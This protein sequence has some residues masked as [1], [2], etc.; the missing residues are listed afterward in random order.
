M[1]EGGYHIEMVLPFKWA[2]DLWG[3]RMGETEGCDLMDGILALKITPGQ[4]RL[5]VFVGNINFIYVRKKTAFEDLP[6]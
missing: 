5:L 6:K 1:T 2:I 3:F 4:T